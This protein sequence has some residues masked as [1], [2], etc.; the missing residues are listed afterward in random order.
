MTPDETIPDFVALLD[1]DEDELLLLL[2]EQVLLAAGSLD[3]DR[4]RA[5]ARAWLD[6]Q[7]D[8]FRTQIC[9]DPWITQLRAVADGDA[10]ETAAAIADLIAGLLGKV[11]AATVATLLVK[12]G[13]DR[14]CA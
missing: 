1:Y 9:A 12:N 7:R 6:A 8:R 4:R 10:A 5:V 14:L 11:P 3:D 2:G 13:L